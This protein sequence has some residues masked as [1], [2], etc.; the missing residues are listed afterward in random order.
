MKRIAPVVLALV[1]ILANIDSADA[2]GRGGHGGGRHFHGG[3]RAHVF[4]GIG[5]SFYFGPYWYGYLPPYG[6]PAV[7]VQ[8]PPVYVQQPPPAHGGL[9]YYCASA[10]AYYPAVATCPEAWVPVPARPN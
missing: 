7:V 10:R 1:I 6:P 8:E 4:V 9:W 5:P 2:R 3:S